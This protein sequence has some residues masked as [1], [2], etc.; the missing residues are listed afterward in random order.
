M[1]TTSLAHRP[2]CRTF[3]ALRLAAAA[4]AVLV[5]LALLAPRAAHAQIDPYRLHSTSIGLTDGQYV[6]LNA[7]F[8]RAADGGRAELPPGPCRVTLR[9]LDERG[10]VVAE[11]VATLRAGRAALLDYRP[12]LRPGARAAVRAELIGERDDAG[13]APALIP[14]IEVID[15][16]TGR[17]TIGSPGTI[18]GFNPQPEPPGDLGLFGL[19]SGQ[20]AH[21]SVAYV[22][23]SSDSGLPPGP[24]NVQITLLNGDGAIVASRRATVA[25]GET[26][27]LDLVGAATPPGVRRRLL[28]KVTTDGRE[29]GFLASAVEVVDEATGKSA[30]M[31][32]SDFVQ[33][34]GWE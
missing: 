23:L 29:Q 9:F 12:T 33:S 19:A 21:V 6:R 31:F 30:A 13:V 3:A 2:R 11:S 17:T 18:R 16:A 22:G 32:P 24:C 10:A 15:V 1:S 14:S 34:W 25:P 26:I 8:D 27:A 4:V 20:A 7:Y 28:A 5:A